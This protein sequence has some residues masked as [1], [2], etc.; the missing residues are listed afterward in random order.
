MGLGLRADEADGPAEL[1]D[2]ADRTWI[3]NSRNT[4]DEDAVRTLGAL[5]GFTRGSPIRSTAW[6]SSR[7]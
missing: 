1:P 2:Y 7:I 6:S 3:V 5:S 4:A